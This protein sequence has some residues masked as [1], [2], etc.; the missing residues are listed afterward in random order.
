MRKFFHQFAYGRYGTDQLSIFLVLGYFFL[1]GLSVLLNLTPFILIAVSML[2]F[3]YYRIFSRNIIARQQ[4]NQ[5]YLKYTAPYW[6]KF[7][8]F[9]LSHKDKTHRYFRCPNCNLRLRAPRN[10]GKIQ[11][12]CRQCQEKFQKET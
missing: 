3:A 1:R 6:D 12:T 10:K 11:V 5:K 8:F 9:I 4:E 2:V 7:N